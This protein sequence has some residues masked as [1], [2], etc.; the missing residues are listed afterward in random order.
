MQRFPP[1]ATGVS[2]L[3]DDVLLEIF[4]SYMDQI[5]H[6]DA[7]YK[8][9]HVCRKW[10]SVVFSSPRW[11]H[12]E[13]RCTNRRPVKGM[14]DIWPAAL[15]IVIVS[16]TDP[17]GPGVT[18]VIAALI[19][20]DRVR[21]INVWGVPNLLLESAAIKKP[22]PQLTNLTL[23]S[24]EENAPVITDSFLGGSAPRLQSLELTGIPLLF[25]ALGKL[26]LSSRN[27]VTFCLW[28]IPNSGIISPGLIVTALSASTMLQQL[29]IGFR[30]PRSRADR[31]HRHPPL[32]ERLVLPSLTKFY[33][34]GDSE[35]L[36]DIV[37]RIDT[38]ALDRFN[39]TF[40]TQLVFNM[41][42]L[43]DFLSRTT[44]FREPHQARVFFNEPSI[45]FNLSHYGGIADCRMLEIRI[46]CSMP[47]WQLSSLA[48]FC[49]IA[50][51]PFPTLERLRIYPGA[52]FPTDM[53]SSQWLELFNPFINVKALVLPL[54]FAR[55]VATALGELTGP[56]VAEV[57]PALR[58]LS[59][60][61][62]FSHGPFR[63]IFAQFVTA[64]QLCGH[65]V[66]LNPAEV[67][68]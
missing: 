13:L 20:H 42:L 8:L 25:P 44:V 9:V 7:W 35:Y 59:V 57:L 65:P 50:L 19:G 11:L 45:E 27:L 62:T 21:R 41:P 68:A 51:P 30:S 14:L 49:S 4:R 67:P 60:N 66:S 1:R 26:L 17:C 36:E 6:E 22:F 12:L 2:S 53:E 56:T 61:E 31:E 43:R 64:R 32:F 23:R 40:F 48:Q 37:G 3:P 15:P 10:R 47:E 24:N 54:S 63:K 28:D 55:R 46:L 16:L 58:Q 52:H 34:K 38:P 5:H 29:F 33:F 18:N 39:I